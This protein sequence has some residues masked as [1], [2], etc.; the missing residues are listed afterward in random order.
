MVSGVDDAVT[1]ES[2]L[3]L[4]GGQF[5]RSRSAQPVRAM[6]VALISSRRFITL[7]LNPLQ[8]K[9]KYAGRWDFQKGWLC[10]NL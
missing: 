6:R 8:Q 10:L 5:R 9:N 1:L 3:F 4:V 7:G 2:A